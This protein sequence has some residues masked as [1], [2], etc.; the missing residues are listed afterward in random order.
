MRSC[1]KCGV[2]HQDT[3][4]TCDCG[5]NLIQTHPKDSVIAA[6]LMKI[7]IWG[8]SVFS[9]L[10]AVGISGVV[11]VPSVI[12]APYLPL[13]VGVVGVLIYQRLEGQA[14]VKPQQGA[15]I[16]LLSGWVTVITVCLLAPPHTTDDL[17]VLICALSI[18]GA[19]GGA[20]CGW[21]IKRISEPV[22][23]KAVATGPSCAICGCPGTIVNVPDWPASFHS[24]SAWASP[25]SLV[26]CDRM[27]RGMCGTVICLRCA[28]KAGK[29]TF[30]CPSCGCYIPVPR[31]MEII[32]KL[33]LFRMTA[34]T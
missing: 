27:G 4:V 3:V 2:R 31:D 14:V 10:I 32:D 11:A 9:L 15:I 23:A 12:I 18:S 17:V 22:Q 19:V 16:G 30:L 20:I 21:I 5:Y 6:F 29:S 1:P 8:I 28:Y 33:H 25:T 34:S 7:G 24:S 13:G 26:H